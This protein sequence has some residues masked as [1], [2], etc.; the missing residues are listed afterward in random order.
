MRIPE[1]WLADVM[2]LD[3][4][5]NLGAWL[6]SESAYRLSVSSRCCPRITSRFE[7]LPGLSEAVKQPTEVKGSPVVLVVAS[8]AL[9]VADLCR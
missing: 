2:G 3:Q 5:G 1:A 4:R 7:D 9:R 8:A 6:A